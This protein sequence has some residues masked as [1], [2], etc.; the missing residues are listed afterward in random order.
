MRSDEDVINRLRAYAFDL[1]DRTQEYVV[2]SATAQ[3]WYPRATRRSARARLATLASVAAVAAAAIAIVTLQLGDDRPPQISDTALAPDPAVCGTWERASPHP[4]IGELRASAI[5]TGE[6]FLIV[7][8]RGPIAEGVTPP[9]RTRALTAAAFNPTTGLWR[10]LPASPLA[11]D[12]AMA[13]VFVDGSAYFAVGNVVGRFDANRNMW[14]QYRV[15]AGSGDVIGLG[16]GT[17]GSVLVITAPAPTGPPRVLAARLLSPAT[18]SWSA[19]SRQ[20]IIDRTG[21]LTVG[22]AVDGLVIWTNGTTVWGVDASGRWSGEQALEMP[23]GWQFRS[24]A[25]AFDPIAESPFALISVQRDD[26][27]GD[28]LIIAR[29]RAGEWTTGPVING[30]GHPSGWPL[31]GLSGRLLSMSTYRAQT[32]VL[33]IADS[34]FAV[35][36]PPSTALFANHAMPSSEDAILIWTDEAGVGWLWRPPK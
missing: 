4:A 14:S 33:N 11:S 21:T 19:P 9:Q 26:G 34:S 10:D 12:S 6:E 31:A 8:G 3:L 5:W 25:T 18:A 7:G 20:E 16:A 30:Q 27:S 24:L 35:C 22:R 23:L 1:D 36:N 13:S 32:A 17:D 29:Q 2:E 28:G 15:P